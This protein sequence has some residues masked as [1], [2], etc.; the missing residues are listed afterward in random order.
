MVCYGNRQSE[1]VW[2]FTIVVYCR[3]KGKAKK[4]LGRTQW[5]QMKVKC[6]PVPQETFQRKKV[7]NLLQLFRAEIEI[8]DTES[9][10]G[11]R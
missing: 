8:E 6:S 4:K 7:N 3:R 9:G 5:Q 2:S 10:D 11:E 1:I